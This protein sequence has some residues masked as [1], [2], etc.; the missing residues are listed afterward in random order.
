LRLPAVFGEIKNGLL[1]R[2]CAHEANGGLPLHF[3][4]FCWT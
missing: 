4:S 3:A 1:S 2:Y